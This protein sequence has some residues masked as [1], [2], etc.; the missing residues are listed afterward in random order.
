MQLLSRLSLARLFSS[1]SSTYVNEPTVT[2]YLSSFR[3]ND[4]DGIKASLMEESIYRRLFAQKPNDL[5]PSQLSLLR[6]SYLNLV[7]V[8]ENQ[9]I[10]KIKNRYFG[11][12]AENVA[13][14]DD[15]DASYIMPLHEEEILGQGDPAICLGGVETFQ[16]NWNL[17]T[18]SSLSGLDWSNV[19]AAGGAV[20]SCLLPIPQVHSVSP[21]KTREWYHD[22]SYKDSDIDLFIYGLDEEAA[23]QKMVDIYEAVCN[24]IPWD[25]E[26]FRSKYC[27]TILSQYP[28]RHIQIVLRLYNSPS[29]ILTGFDVDCCCVGF[30]GR[31]VW[32]LPRAHQAIIK[33]CNTVDLTRR[34]PSYEMRLAKYAGRGFEI[35]VPS[36]DRSR[37]DPTIYEK[38]F[39]KLNGLARLLVLERLNTP[40]DRFEYIEKKRE[41]NYHPE[42]SSY[43]S[44]RKRRSSDIKASKFENND[45]GTVI[46]PYGPKY[47]AKR[48]KRL[49]YT[50]DMVL[51]SKWY[52]KNKERVLHRHPCFFGTMEQIFNDCCG[53]CPVPSTPE[54]VASQIEED[55]I[56]I[57]GKM[58]FI[59]D[60]PG[61]QTVGSFHPLT[62]NDWATQAYITNVR[63]DLC[64]AC[65]RGEVDVVEN[66]LKQ[67]SNI[68]EDSQTNKVNVEARDYLGRTPLQLAVLGGHTE[69]VRILLQHDAR[70]T[71]RMP[72]GKT[73]VHLSSQYGYL[74]ILKLLLQK[75]DE[76]KKKAQEKEKEKL[77]T[78]N[79]D[80]IIDDSLEMVNGIQG[81][82]IASKD[83]DPDSILDP[84]NENEHV[85]IVDINGESR[86]HPLT[87]LEYAILF[88]NVEIVRQLVKAGANVQ[89]LIKLQNH[90]VKY[91][92]CYPLN[93]C[94][95][96]QDQKSGLEIAS[97]LLENGA[98]ASR[99]G[100]NFNSILHFAVK[101]GKI[102]FVK[103]F[104]DMD[105]KS[106]QQI[107]SLNSHLESPLYLA[108]ANN[109]LEITELL[110]KYGA[111]AY[112]TL[113]K[114]QEYLNR[115]KSS[116]T[117]ESLLKSVRQPIFNA[118]QNN[119][120]CTLIEAGVDV[121]ATYYK[122]YIREIEKLIDDNKAKIKGYEEMLEHL[123]GKKKQTQNE[124]RVTNILQYL[125]GLIEKEKKD[126]KGSYR[127]YA[128][129]HHTIEDFYEFLRRKYPALCPPHSFQKPYNSEDI[130][131]LKEKYAK[132]I[133]LEISKLNYNKE[134]LEY[135]INHGT[136]NSNIPKK[137]M[138]GY[139]ERILPEEKAEMLAA[140][141]KESYL[142]E[143]IL[144]QQAVKKQQEEIDEIEQIN[145]DEL[146]MKFTYLD[147]IYG[148][149]I[150]AK[151]NQEYMELYQA[152][153]V[154]DI[155][156][157]EKLSQTLV[158]AVKDKFDMS[159]FMWACLR[160]HSE[161]AVKILDIV[162]SQ[163][164][165]K[166]IINSNEDDENESINA[167]NN[168]DIIESSN[169]PSDDRMDYTYQEPSQTTLMNV[170]E[171]KNNNKFRFFNIKPI[172]D[173]SIFQFLS[174]RK[175]FV[176]VE[177]IP[178]KFLKESNLS[179]NKYYLN[180]FDVAVLKNDL[181]MVK[182]ILDWAERYQNIEDKNLEKTGGL[183]TYLV[184]GLDNH[185]KRNPMIDSIYFGYVDMM[186]LLIEYA[187]G[188]NNFSIFDIKD[189]EEEILTFKI[190]KYYQGL[191]VNGSKKKSWIINYV[192]GFSNN[193]DVKPSFIFYAAYY[194]NITS[195]QYFFSDRPINAL[196]K[197]AYKYINNNSKD[198]RVTILNTIEDIQKV[199]RKLFIYELF[200]NE[201]PFHWAVEGNKHCA[202]EELVKLYSKEKEINDQIGDNNKE[203]H[204]TIEEILDMR[205]D[206][207]KVTALLLAAHFGYNECVRTLLKVGANPEIVD[208]NGWS[209]VH[210]AANKNNIGT[211]KLLY[212]LL[213]PE[214]YQKMLK[215]RSK[216]FNHTP[217]SISILESNI[218]LTEYLLQHA[219]TMSLFARDFEGNRYL[220]LSL[221][222]GLWYISK[223]LIELESMAIAGDCEKVGTLFHENSFGQ[224]PTDIAIQMFL[225]KLSDI[226][227]E[228][229][230]S[231]NNKQ[232]EKEQAIE[233]CAIKAF[234]LMVPF[235]LPRNEG[236]PLSKRVL[237]EFNQVNDMTHKLA[238]KISD[239]HGR[240]I[241]SKEINTNAEIY[242]SIFKY[243]SPPSW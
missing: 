79:N 218:K 62:D 118:L 87:P 209:L 178:E 78:N 9:D 96:T 74:D 42:S 19:F 157:V 86:D 23:K 45:Y 28:S 94:L 193:K 242:P 99:I 188:G 212:E 29:E 227:F 4:V 80:M 100:Y 127:E 197:F 199:G 223:K 113:E 16:K 22:I 238:K 121:N 114:S 133:E 68:N 165:P 175:R 228:S 202:I 5:D 154:N 117:A 140:E 98:S 51:N 40:Y 181:K 110:I 59:K 13:N 164:V 91:E 84:R 44:R 116:E 126:V 17:F 201:T 3:K 159:P 235:Y 50:K 47:N 21:R 222:E 57:R 31:N 49:I 75:S 123:N 229:P 112:I 64:N 221:R 95:L 220:H 213:Q 66:L 184:Q 158:L 166:K 24:S 211:I 205:T 156:K 237:V 149:T 46:L 232:V 224:T 72:D 2:K 104:L 162:S 167:I 27:V 83:Q 102:Q 152:V 142:N 208:R 15:E 48:I 187:A 115:R 148:K 85:D 215:K 239:G 20:L 169:E 194:G 39:E 151:L 225:N 106:L 230:F 119:L 120:Y 179:Q 37:I 10:W 53:H 97:I 243:W 161:L 155:S 130:N 76:N 234:N 200:C 160:G 137:L 90:N 70:I 173:Y 132:L 60:D 226:L 33:Q 147:S 8:Y 135:C 61:R 54:E 18:E 145:F 134:C 182:N 108:V 207:K 219:S 6:Q 88:G 124:R 186:D 176:N 196:K 41:R 138:K 105:P 174:Y 25:V 35:K 38:S 204:L 180:G 1:T 101:I 172:S 131:E 14:D 73:V 12:E 56:F 190:P 63:E 81:P 233:K 183:V 168:Y 198:L 128:L 11:N 52:E 206:R 103:L 32:A 67:N 36:L 71:A 141:E 163:Y 144:L 216:S 30:D 136:K 58:E 7:N 122:E 93:L 26:C 129:N 109:H 153:Y 150:P 77:E 231:P 146:I 203:H 43:V 185:C 195:I 139:Q 192:P 143:E 34:S 240:K 69:I 189:P 92:P 111:T 210:H 125:D 65:A 82:S 170:F 177:V 214:T 241:I 171:D 191:D 89:R 217:I 55:K 107:N 236:N